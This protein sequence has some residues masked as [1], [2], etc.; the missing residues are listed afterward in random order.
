MRTHACT[1]AKAVAGGQTQ[2]E[3][4]RDALTTWPK[5]VRP[6]VHWSESQEGRKPH[7]HSDYIRVCTCCSSA[8]LA[9][10]CQTSGCSVPGL[11]GRVSE[12][13]C[14][15]CCFQPMAE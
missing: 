7:A 8:L 3:A 6:I 2:E 9:A 11:R 1:E 13:V 14:L 4:L 12:A 5:G 10:A 15:L